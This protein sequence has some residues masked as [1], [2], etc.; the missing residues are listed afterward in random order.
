MTH[1]SSIEQGWGK[2]FTTKR[3]VHAPF[4][5]NIVTSWPTSMVLIG[6]ITAG[7]E[8]PQGWQAVEP[9]G[10]GFVAALP[11]AGVVFTVKRDADTRFRLR[12]A[13]IYQEY[14]WK[15]E[16]MPQKK[17]AYKTRKDGVPIHAMTKDL[18]AIK[19]YQEVFC[20]SARVST[21]YVKVSVENAFDVEQVIELGVLVRTGPE[22]LFTGCSDPD[23]YGGYNPTRAHW[24]VPEMKRYEKKEGYLTDG[25]YKLYYDEKENF[26]LDGEND[27]D[28]LLKLK[29]F[30]KRTFTFA[31]TR[32]E[33]KPKNYQTAKRQAEIFWK[34]E[35]G[36]A[37]YIP[38][39]K[40]IAPLF[41]N[42]LAQELQMFAC[43]RGE[44]YTI[45]R[46]GATQRF[47]W[48][49]AKEIIKALAYIGGYSE[50]IDAGLAHYFDVMQEKDGENIGRIHYEFVPWNSR[51]AV[52][53]EMFAAAVR[54]DESFYEKYINQAMLAF[55]WMERERAKSSTME[56]MYKGIFPAGV[57][58]DNPT[59]AQQQWSFA[60]TCNLRAIEDFKQL[61][62]E[63]NSEYLPEVQAAYDDY[64]TVM[65]GIFDK[66]ANEQRDSKKLFLPRDP[67]NT[68]EEDLKSFKDAFMYMFPNEVLSVGLAGYGTENAEKLIKTYSSG[69]QSKNGLIYP[70]YRSTT[71]V[72]RTWYTTWAERERFTYYLLSGKLAECKKL[73]DA[74]LKYN[75]TTEYYQGERYDD[76]DAYIAPWQPNA[77]ANG[78]VLQMLFEFYG[79]KEM[80]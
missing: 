50:Y 45:M 71:G 46:Q 10:A 1:L 58:T 16:L 80:K 11:S 55:R 8:R 3:Y 20:D 24:E 33:K 68:I 22:F 31:F 13:K 14:T 44:N 43:P 62:K 70:V 77:S 19:F 54:S 52:S 27:L 7:K 60:D 39:K 65:K 56:G 25:T 72:G 2:P 28:I 74:L 67:R 61:L 57:A 75:V 9:F 42:F 26:V 34:K 30:E 12:E 35:L 53:L 37:K 23:G 36:K 18:D 49:E 5:E 59:A 78:R 17:V 79:K 63:K 38:A 66:F 40:G 69:N 6:E 51:T 15:H 47:H 73:I 21:A 48:P 4:A 41:Y 76:H 64:F 29:P 32:N